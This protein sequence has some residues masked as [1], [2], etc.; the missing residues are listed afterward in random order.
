MLHYSD[1]FPFKLRV[2]EIRR[3]K[4]SIPTKDFKERVW[5]IFYWK[6][7]DFPHRNDRSVTAPNRLLQLLDRGPPGQH[8][9]ADLQL[10][11]V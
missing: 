8:L 7:F 4:R 11:S 2:E 1:V 3:K 10:F 5:L 9:S 6:F